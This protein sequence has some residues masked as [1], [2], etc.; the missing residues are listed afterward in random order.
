MAHKI[1]EDIQTRVLNDIA[2]ALDGRLSSDIAD[3]MVDR[4]LKKRREAIVPAI[5]KHAEWAAQ[6]KK[7]ESNPDVKVYGSDMKPIGEPTFSQKKVDEINQLRQ[8]IEKLEKAI[9]K[10][11][12]EGDL[13]D[14]NQL[15]GSGG[16]DQKSGEAEAGGKAP[17]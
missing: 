14:V 16:K 4:E 10:A 7:L 15:L 17:D 1:I 2:Q 13:K 9:I 11:Y 5:D 8:K 12:S 6:L 3:M